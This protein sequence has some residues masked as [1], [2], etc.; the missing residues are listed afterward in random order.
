MT[1]ADADRAAPAVAASVNDNRPGPGAPGRNAGSDLRSLQERIRRLEGPRRAAAP[2]QPLGIPAIDAHLPGGGLPT[3][4]VHAVTAAAPG[5]LGA[6]T[7]FAGYVLARLAGAAPVL[8]IQGATGARDLY[9]P[10]LRPLGLAAGQLLAV[11]APSAA[12][13]L[14]AAEEG[15]RSPALAAVAVETAGLD[16]TA[17]RRLQL[18]AET[19]GTTGLVLRRGAGT[20]AQGAPLLPPG[21][22]TSR[23]QVRALATAAPEGLPGAGGAAWEVALQRCRGTTPACWRLEVDDAA[24]SCAVAAAA[25]DGSAP[26]A[27]GAG[28]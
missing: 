11:H 18:A 26:A 6:A 14:W 25:A 27:V 28:G 17:A 1:W 12:E 20:D 4:A 7:G 21:A 24:G 23:W 10:G 13:A 15:L 2:S 16:L 3:L 8:W 22:L 9:L 19:G 5:D